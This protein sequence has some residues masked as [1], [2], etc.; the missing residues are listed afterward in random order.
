[1]RILLFEDDEGT[2]LLTKE[3][4]E[5]ENFEMDV[6][7]NGAEGIDKAKSVHYDIIL[8]DLN[9]PDL[10]GLEIF[11]ELKRNNPHTVAVVITGSGD[12]G[13]AVRAMKNGAADYIVKSP[14]M[15]YLET[16][17]TVIRKVLEQKWIALER[18]RLT[19]ELQTTNEELKAKNEEL[20]ARLKMLKAFEKMTLDREKRILDLKEE[21]KKLKEKSST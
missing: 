8:L 9:M 12:E 6:A 3:F 16:L 10:N 20:G 11:E 4:L 13:Y 7:F 5:R 19:K 2:A 17:P 14:D 1:M 15:S 21:I 18:D